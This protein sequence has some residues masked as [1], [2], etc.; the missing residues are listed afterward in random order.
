MDEDSVV[1]R[2]RAGDQAAFS[3]LVEAYGPA[4]YRL[5]CAI[6]RSGSDAEDAAQEAFI[7]AWRELPTLRDVGAWPAWLRRISVHVAL[8][9]SRRNRLRAVTLRITS[10]SSAL[11]LTSVVT[12]RQELEEAFARL[13]VA[14]RTILVL[15]YY[16]DLEVPDAALALGI[17][18]G[19]AKS[20][21]HRALARLRADME[22]T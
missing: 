10:P 11:D 12:D 4:T 20:R 7:R 3:E 19:T 21:L 13:S 1:F 16:L 8:D 5:C 18:L 6:L 14:D 2:A 22:A 15:R 17:P 9:A